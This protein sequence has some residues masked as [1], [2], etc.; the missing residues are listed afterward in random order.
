MGSEKGKKQSLY[1][2]MITKMETSGNKIPS[3]FVMFLYIT[4]AL[5]IITT[6]LALLRVHV[7]DPN[8]NQD[9]YVKS[10]FS[11]E[12]FGWFFPNFLKN[13]MNY[14]PFGLVLLV[15]VAVNLAE[16]V[17][18]FP[19]V[20]KR[21]LSNVPPFL[22]TLVV[23]FVAIVFNF[24]GDA[25]IV[26]V[27]PLAGLI[28]YMIGRSPIV[29][30]LAGYAVSAG[31]FG[32]NIIVTS[33]DAL[34]YPLTNGALSDSAQQVTMVSNWYFFAASCIIFTLVGTFI[35]IKFIEPKF[36]DLPLD[37]VNKEELEEAEITPIQK[38][39]LRNVII[40]VVIFIAVLLVMLVPKHGLL[41]GA[42]GSLIQS[43]F[44]D[45]IPFVIF[46]FFVVIAMVY[47]IT[48][49]QIHK[50]EDVPV[51]FGKAVS[52]LTGFIATIFILAQFIAIFN[53]TKLGNVIALGCYHF[54]DNLGINGIWMLFALII[55]TMITSIFIS[56]ASAMWSMFAPMFVPMMVLMGFS[57]AITQ[58]AFRVGAP[59]LT[60]VSPFMV[61][62]PMVMTYMSKYT[63][64]FNI[65]MLLAAMI[66]YAVGFF[67][68]WIIQ[69]VIWIIFKIPLGP[70]AP[71]YI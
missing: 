67:I 5:L 13:V 22:L 11:A 61:Y 38:K 43:P 10:L 56:S 32:S 71:I 9:V 60:I 20:I 50:I 33:Y 34:L 21:T 35:T 59:I 19:V 54:A 68:V 23:C 37:N 8:S 55:I 12:G 1:N 69:F 31:V 52:T 24:A 58:T 49:Q 39:G 45:G 29:G 6:V 3:P 57:P 16:Q 28:F 51:M 41:R 25:A 7:Y 53:W 62:I 63:K 48:T 4:I 36:K 2:R 64:K 30:I 15:T 70:G 18:L 40:S 46:A 65:G 14:A 17:G 27:P 66:P 26:V 42:D 44:M 47:G